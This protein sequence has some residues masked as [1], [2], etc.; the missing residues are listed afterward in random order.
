MPAYRAVG[1]EARLCVSDVLDHTL[2]EYTLP[3]RDDQ[4]QI[5]DDINKQYRDAQPL[6]ERTICEEDG[7]GVVRF[8]GDHNDIPHLLVT[9][10]HDL[11]RTHENCSSRL[12]K[13]PIT[14]SAASSLT[15][16]GET[17]PDIVPIDSFE[18]QKHDTTTMDITPP[19]SPKLRS[20]PINSIEQT[21]CPSTK[22]LILQVTVP[23]RAYLRSKYQT[24]G[25]PDIKVEVFLN[26]K[27]AA[28]TLLHARDKQKVELATRF[29]GGTRSGKQSERPWAIVVPCLSTASIGT[30]DRSRKAQWDDVGDMLRRE[31]DGRGTDKYA[32]YQP[33]AGEYT[34]D[35]PTNTSSRSYRTVRAF[36]LI[37]KSEYLRSVSNLPIPANVESASSVG[38]LDMGIID[39]VITLG[40][41][42][43]FDQG[44]GLLLHPDTL[45][46]PDG[47]YVLES[48]SDK[49]E[50]IAANDTH[51]TA[52]VKNL[53]QRSFR[54]INTAI[55]VEE[56][57][58][59]APFPPFP[60]SSRS[61]PLSEAQQPS[62]L[63]AIL[64]DEMQGVLS[65]PVEPST[66]PPHIDKDSMTFTPQFRNPLTDSAMCTSKN[67]ADT[68]PI[69]E[70]PAGDGSPLTKRLK[71]SHTAHDHSDGPPATQGTSIS[72]FMS[73]LQPH[74]DPT[75]TNIIPGLIPDTEL[76][77]D[78][79]KAYGALPNGP[80][81]QRLDA[82]IAALNCDTDTSTGNSKGESQK[83]TQFSSRATA[84]SGYGMRVPVKQYSSSHGIVSLPFSRAVHPI[85]RD[86]YP[87]TRS[88]SAP[89][90]AIVALSMMSRLEQSI[91]AGPTSDLIGQDKQGKDEPQLMQSQHFKDLTPEDDRLLTT[92][93]L[94]AATTRPMRQ[95]RSIDTTVIE[96]Q[97]TPSKST[98]LRDSLPEAI[99]APDEIMTDAP[100]PAAAPIQDVATTSTTLLQ[101]PFLT[102][103]PALQ[104]KTP[105]AR[106]TLRTRKQNAAAMSMT[107]KA[108]TQQS[109][110]GL[111]ILTFADLVPL[112]A[113]T[114]TG[115]ATATVS[116][117]TTTATATTNVT[118]TATTDDEDDDEDKTENGNGE[119]VRKHRLVKKERA[120]V[121]R[122]DSVLCG[123]RFVVG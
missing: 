90:D 79:A 59:R 36:E 96:P 112:E 88:V 61:V 83:K 55:Q 32:Q 81:M 111:S 42:K 109:K 38:N 5:F 95:I 123:M 8:V 122:E 63:P 14:P 3:T 35:R 97:A 73:E 84:L 64:V 103:T 11:I 66:P 115:T 23:E 98:N 80:L 54:S 57:P 49:A 62:V 6:T 106:S 45:P 117:T 71:V 15:I 48:R 34:A 60:L 75:S 101:S 26:G 52:P 58:F 18:P 13:A 93:L 50:P 108:E 47:K 91:S 86:F 65:T 25:S 27:F 9:A 7:L 21:R 41:G 110:G 46:D 4:Y 94:T 20:V 17:P 74:A 33:A 29:F 92:A 87:L 51:T 19:A 119:R 107:C 68:H 104:T 70:E 76:V 100:L 10:G 105:V 44:H 31:T 121:F 120:G 102:T 1:V 37:C 22:A 24:T 113:S 53:P 43:K 67:M 116:A 39:V 16:L 77:T 56:I 78:V 30:S 69:F 118:A 28:S 114:S 85:P 12:Q 40:K 99:S 89:G 2:H 82:H 72:T